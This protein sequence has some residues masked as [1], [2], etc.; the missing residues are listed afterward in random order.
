MNTIVY[1]DGFNFY[2]GAVRKTPY[3]WL[4]FSRLCQFLLPKNK[5]SQIKYFTALVTPRLNNPEKAM[6]QQVY[7]R[8]L[9]T[10]PNLEIIRGHFLDHE[11]MMPLAG[12][13]GSQQQYV[14]V[15]KTEEKGSDVNIAAHM[16]N[17]GYKG[18]Y[19]AAILISN[20]SDLVEPIRIVRTELKL[21]VGVLNPHQKPSQQLLK[22]ASFV[23]PI[24]QGVLS[25]SQ[26][27]PVLQDAQG[28]ITKP[29]SW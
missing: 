21:P 22:F 6:R 3:K 26:F 11:V 8:A 23:K 15:I 13:S 10:I 25:A 7:L 14:R 29:A 17:D 20:D 12:N 2:Y 24:R 28:I 27:P 19:Q 5:I 4:D 18:L 9:R 16:I 1:I